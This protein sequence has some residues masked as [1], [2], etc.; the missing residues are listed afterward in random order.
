MLKKPKRTALG[1]FALRSLVLKAQRCYGESCVH[2]HVRHG[3]REE[4]EE[5][6]AIPSDP[7]DSQRFP[8]FS[9]IPSDSY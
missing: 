2:A 8:G 9:T 4:R 7:N 5:I 3:V 6:P 1:K